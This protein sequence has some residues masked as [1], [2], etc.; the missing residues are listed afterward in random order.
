M[1]A[2]SAASPTWIRMGSDNCLVAASP[3]H[4]SFGGVSVHLFFH[5]KDGRAEGGVTRW[6]AVLCG[7]RTERAGV[8]FRSLSRARCVGGAPCIEIRW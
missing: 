2:K 7:G 8:A 5:F 6:K 1:I 3:P 4:L